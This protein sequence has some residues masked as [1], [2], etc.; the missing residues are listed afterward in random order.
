MLTIGGAID[1]RPSE[2]DLRPTGSEHDYRLVAA[3]GVEKRQDRPVTVKA[4]QDEMVG[5]YCWGCGADNPVG[6]HLQSYWNGRTAIAEWNPGHEYAAGPQHFL[7]GGIIATLLDCHG[8]CTAVASAYQREQRYVGTEPEIWFATASITV[9]YLRPSPI[10]SLVQLS[11]Q[12]VAYD[13]RTATVECV[14]R[15]AEKER[16][17]AS[18]RAI[19]VPDEWRHGSAVTPGR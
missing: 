6:L 11:A 8:I 5:N 12:V 7:N 9:D 14:L 17:R 2:T 3:A 13:D 18:V 4:I 1:E 16:A 19:R 10:D 15:A